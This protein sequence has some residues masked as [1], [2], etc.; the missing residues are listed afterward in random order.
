M[1]LVGC[2][3]RIKGQ[4]LKKQVL[5]RVVFEGMGVCAHGEGQMGGGGA[6]VAEK[7]S[8]RIPSIFGASTD[9]ICQ[10]QIKP[11]ASKARVK[12]AGGGCGPRCV[13]RD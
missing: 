10:R 7:V 11:P 1:Y 9:A 8:K 2:N 13:V 6:G 4:A 3:I 12:R 5:G